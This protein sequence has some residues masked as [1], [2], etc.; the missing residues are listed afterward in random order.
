MAFEAQFASNPAL[1][2]TAKP[3]PKIILQ[4]GDSPGS[5]FEGFQ[6]LLFRFARDEGS[7]SAFKRWLSM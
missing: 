2:T 4:G 7:P 5:E 6:W 3:V 1:P